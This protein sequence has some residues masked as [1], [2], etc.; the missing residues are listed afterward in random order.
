MSPWLPSD[1]PKLQDDNHEV[2]SPT[3]REY[4]CIAWAADETDRVWWTVPPPYAYW[5]PEAPLVTTLD[6]FIRAF[7]TR[8]YEP[9][10]N[11]QIEPGYEKVVIYVDANGTPTHM[12]RQLESGVWTSKLGP[13]EDIEHDTLQDLEG[14]VYGHAVQALRRP[15]DNGGD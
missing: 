5:P 15:Y 7:R 1:F 11:F 10:D 9:A 2:K 6:S 12:A 14:D 8:G 4:N 3:T 13:Q